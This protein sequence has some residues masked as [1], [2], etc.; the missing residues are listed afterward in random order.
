MKTRILLSAI[1][2]ISIIAACTTTI[3]VRVRKPAELNVG[4]ARTIAVMD[5]DFTG[6][7][8]FS[9]DKKSKTKLRNVL[10]NVLSG[11]GTI[12]N[13]SQKAY[14]GSNVSDQFVAKLVQNQYYTVIERSRIE[15]I[16]KEQ[17]FSL[18]GLVD[19]Q[20]AVTI[21]NL[22]GAE[23]LIIGS[24][25]YSIKDEGG[26]ETYKEQEKDKNGK[27]VEVE[28]ERYNI[29]RIVDASLTFR[30]I[31]VSTGSII[32]SK[33]NTGSN[34]SAKRSYMGTGKDEQVAAQS[35]PD[36]KPIVD[37][38]VNDVLNRTVTQI[39]PHTVTEKRVIEEGDS[40]KMEKALEY[41][42]RDLWD[43]ARVIWQE[44]A[45][46]KKSDKDD[47]IAAT[48]NLGLYYE[49]F[50]FL[51]DA[52]N[53]YQLAFKLSGDSKFLDARARINRRREELK[54][55]QQQEYGL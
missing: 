21:G 26:W 7:W 47:K 6:S 55:L 43:E 30:I 29:Y 16:I 12:S 1:F 38:V 18:S 25:S 2:F 40:N 50:G 23:A 13:N 31:D 52:E 41:A 4:A 42:K 10:K 32:A 44:V 27:K 48:Y 19:E 14:P 49:V 17:S 8:D 24:G 5:F 36:W 15:E 46:K 45:D 34:R 54:K 20:Q 3:P 22:L 39:A 28:K 53:Y 9:A 51:D 33:T 37:R 35:L 11:A